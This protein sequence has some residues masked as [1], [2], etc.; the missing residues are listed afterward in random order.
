MRVEQLAVESYS[1][2]IRLGGKRGTRKKSAYNAPEAILERMI[3]FL[4]DEDYISLAQ[5]CALARSI[6][7]GMLEADKKWEELVLDMPIEEQLKNGLNKPPYPP[8]ELMRA[9][10]AVSR[11]VE[12]E[13]KLKFGDANLI[14]IESAIGFALAIATLVNQFVSS[15]EEKKAVLDG[16]KGLL[17]AGKGFDINLRV[18]RTIIGG[19]ENEGG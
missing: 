16:V 7:D 2:P 11:I 13:Y 12:K 10:T 18:A 5:E 9:I 14:T 17:V 15:P 1:E 8:G 6:L 19:E 4:E 3:S